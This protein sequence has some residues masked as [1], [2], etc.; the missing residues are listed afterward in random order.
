MKTHIRLL[1]PAIVLFLFASCSTNR[2]VLDDRGRLANE[3][4]E[5]FLHSW[6][7]YKKYAWGSDMLRPVSKT[8]VNW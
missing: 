7:A 6:N 2:A 4:R 5:E 3:V 1:V 8:P